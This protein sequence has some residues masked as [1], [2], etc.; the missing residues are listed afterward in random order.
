MK[1]QIV[2]LVWELTVNAGADCPLSC[3]CSV[4]YQPLNDDAVTDVYQ[5]KHSFMLTSC[6]ASFDSAS[7]SVP[8][9]YLF[10]ADFTS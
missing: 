10:D 6:K 3:T 8:V 2:S 7:L 9:G 4:N 1:A 5:F